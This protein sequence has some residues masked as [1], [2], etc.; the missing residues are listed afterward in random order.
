MCQLLGNILEGSRPQSSSPWTVSQMTCTAR[1]RGRCTWERLFLYCCKNI[2]HELYPLNRFS[3]HNTVLSPAGSTR[4]SRSLERAH[5]SNWDLVIGYS[6]CSPASRPSR[7]L[8]FHFTRA[9]N[10]P[11]PSQV[12]TRSSVCELN[13]H[14]LHCSDDKDGGTSETGTLWTSPEIQ[15]LRLC[16]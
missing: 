7:E 6:L 1:L 10:A 2:S 9:L 11:W 16:F 15:W 12:Y 13:K 14:T 5:L 4:H 3:V 8:R